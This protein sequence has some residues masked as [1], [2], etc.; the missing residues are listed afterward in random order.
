MDTFVQQL[1]NGLTIGAISVQTAQVG[2]QLCKR[3]PGCSDHEQGESAS[4]V[5]TSAANPPISWSHAEFRCP[6]KVAAYLQIYPSAK[7]CRR[8]PTSI[9]T[10][11]ALRRILLFLTAF[12]CS[13]AAAVA[14]NAQT[15]SAEIGRGNHRAEKVVIARI[16]HG[17]TR[18]SK[19]DEY[20]EY[21]N[22]AGI[23]NIQ[24][25]EG[26]LGVQVLRRTT[27]GVTEFTVISYWESIDAIRR[28][29]GKE[30]EK[31]HHLPKDYFYLLELEP[32]VKH[33]E[34]V[35]DKRK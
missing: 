32:R 8:E 20:Y 27:R 31:T 2:R 5:K 22:K 14:Q 33:F 17:R 10:S 34:V 24:A 30:I 19:A 7:T 29:A 21:L 26:N 11:G 4:R 15:P 3:S 25:V 9:R 18:T 16:W 1:I 12:V 23:K 13:S 28:F 35:L 6:R